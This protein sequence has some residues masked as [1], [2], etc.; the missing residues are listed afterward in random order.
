MPIA[1]VAKNYRE[2]AVKTATPAQLVLMLFDG[3]LRAMATA[4]KGFDIEAIAPR[5]EQINNQLIKAQAI[6]RELQASLDLKCGGEFASRMWALYDFML[7]RLHVANVA[8]DPEPIRI[9]ERL[10]GEVRDAWA[11][12]LEKTRTEAA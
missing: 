6:L 8:K 11:T 3:G 2:A 1:Q 5:F 12:M 9:V 10:L 4:L 7:E